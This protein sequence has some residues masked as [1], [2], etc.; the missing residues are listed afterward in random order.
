MSAQVYN[1]NANAITVY[2]VSAPGIPLATVTAG[3]N[4]A[5]DTAGNAFYFVQAGTGDMRAFNAGPGAL[6]AVDAQGNVTVAE[7]QSVQSLLS[8]NLDVT[9]FCW[10]LGTGLTFGAVFLIVH[11][12]RSVWDD[13]G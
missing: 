7:T 6:V 11:L 1:T 8:A 12:L 4:E 5:I 2:S 10:G 3:G 13:A 9:G